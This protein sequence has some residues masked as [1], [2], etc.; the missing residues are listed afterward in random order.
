MSQ[1]HTTI[2]QSDLITV[3]A[4]PCHVLCGGAA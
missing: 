2:K 1:T 4:E 3:L